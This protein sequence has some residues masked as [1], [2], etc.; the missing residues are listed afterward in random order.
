MSN[1]QYERDTSLGM[2]WL[3]LI[4]SLAVL[5]LMLG[6]AKSAMFSEWRHYQ[7]EYRDLLMAKAHSSAGRQSARDYKIELHATG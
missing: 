2:K 5:A 3:L 1:D 4:C 6:V 7:S